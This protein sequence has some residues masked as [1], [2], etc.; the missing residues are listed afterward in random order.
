MFHEYAL[1]LGTAVSRPRDKSPQQVAF[2]ARSPQLQE[3]SSLSASLCDLLGLLPRPG[4]AVNRQAMANLT[5]G[6][7]LCQDFEVYRELLPNGRISF[8]H[9][10]FFISA[11][12]GGEE[13]ATANCEL[14]GA[15]IVID[16]FTF[17]AH[18]SLHCASADVVAR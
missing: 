7:L 4:A 18:R 8:E 1:E 11:L 10:V 13:L 17:K 9:L 5:R 14:C 3:E 6:K 16:R 15:L 2:F 12:V